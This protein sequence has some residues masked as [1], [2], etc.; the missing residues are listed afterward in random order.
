MPW[1]DNYY[2]RKKRTG[3][4]V[5]SEYVGTGAFAELAAALDE[6][7]RQKRKAELEQHRRMVEADRAIVRQINEIGATVVNITKMALIVDGYHQHR[8]QWRRDT[9]TETINVPIK[10]SE[11]LDI[12]AA[13]LNALI[14]RVDGSNPTKEDKQQLAKYL[15][16][17]PE[18]AAALGDMADQVVVSMINRMYTKAP[19]HRTAAGIDFLNKQ[20]EFGYDEANALEKTMIMHIVVCWIRLQYVEQQFN[21]HVL[22]EHTMR[23]GQYWDR[24]L[25]AA[26]RRYLRAVE[27]LARVRR[28]MR[29]DSPTTAILMQQSVSAG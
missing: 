8:R 26:Q 14:E 13:E 27:S 22:G 12:S 5:Q 10:R 17:V 25:S 21:L 16:A 4:T 6:A 28:L 23:E 2:Y 3:D 11:A 1:R 18:L 24:R 20:K 9:M 19:S 15:A 7:E 29:P